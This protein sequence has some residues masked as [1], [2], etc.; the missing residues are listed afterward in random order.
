MHFTF[1]GVCS[2]K[3]AIV[4]IEKGFAQ[5]LDR[6]IHHGAQ[7]GLSK[8]IAHGLCSR[9]YAQQNKMGDLGSNK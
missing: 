7:D 5:V 3:H 4:S 1:L 9:K 8:A 2:W 6:E